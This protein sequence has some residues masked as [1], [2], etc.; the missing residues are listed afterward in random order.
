MSN[1]IHVRPVLGF[2]AK[3]LRTPVTIFAGL[4]QFEESLQ[5]LGGS[6]SAISRGPTAVPLDVGLV[7][8]LVK[9]GGQQ[10]FFGISHNYGARPFRISHEERSVRTIVVVKVL[11]TISNRIPR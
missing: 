11:E 5:G 4:N 6:G 7:L 10:T 3:V 9:I 2:H 1:E 8:A